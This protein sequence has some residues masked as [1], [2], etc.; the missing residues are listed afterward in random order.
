MSGLLQFLRKHI[1]EFS[2]FFFFFVFYYFTMFPGAGGR[3]FFGDSIKWQYLWKVNGIPH[4][5][6]YPQYLLLSE[7]FSRVF[8]LLPEPE[9]ITLISVFFGAVSLALFYAVAKNL[10]AK[11]G[12]SIMATCLL[13]VSYV[14][15][16]QSTEAE[17]Y[18]LNTAFL[19]AVIILF[20]KFYETKKES[21][22]LWG[23]AVYSLSFGNHLSM[24]TAL[25]AIIFIAFYTDKSVIFKRKNLFA[26][27]LFIVAGALQYLFIYYRAH[28]AEAVQQ[29][30]EVGLKPTLLE[31]VKF[32]T[33]GQYKGLMVAFSFND[34]MFDRFPLLLQYINTNF[35][36]FGIALISA[37]FWYCLFVLRKNIAL[38]FLLLILAGQVYFFIGYN[39]ADLIVFFMP[40]Y[41]ITAL[42]SAFIFMHP[43][44]RWLIPMAG[45]LVIYI[46]W[47]NINR[48][49]I[50]KENSF[51]VRNFSVQ[52]DI[53]KN[54]NDT[55]PMYIPL[56]AYHDCVYFN[57]QNINHAYGDKKVIYYGAD[58][59]NSFDSFYF[60][61]DTNH[62]KGFNAGYK[63]EVV[64][65]VDVTDFIRNNSSDNNL[66]FIALRNV[67]NQKL[68]EN[69]RKY[70]TS[71]GS[72]L[73]G[74]TGNSA[75]LAVM[76][77]KSFQEKISHSESV[78]L[79]NT[80]AEDAE[81][82]EIGFRIRSAGPATGDFAVIR[83]GRTDYS[84]NENG[85]NIVVYDKDQKC[86]TKV[87][88]FD[89]AAD[90]KI[91]LYKA[92]RRK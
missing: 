1:V 13:S 4:P 54:L 23:C 46:C 92:V 52:E 68:P 71:A 57:Y 8:V 89:L 91:S 27:T 84:L 34:I 26:V 24:I 41:V 31:L 88:S 55:L 10:T 28:D 65:E 44:S 2:V 80:E 73:T 79:Y 33:G 90:D 82:K 17:V 69:L 76:S 14:F 40:V 61:C 63:I 62:V 81:I 51:A 29:F 56:W 39:V 67:N 70:L 5:T 59:I 30:S 21:Y 47:A 77:G 58:R 20:L 25:P 43:V 9:R 78:Q 75:Y 11:T 53:Y 86:V 85:L 22:Y 74:F 49:D 19:L 64:R 45:I 72:G 48:T 87:T 32:V 66:V 6:G 60:I 42:F 36:F 37:G 18:T 3:I 35:T 38:I 16:S 7:L 83:I 15:W 50:V 12:G